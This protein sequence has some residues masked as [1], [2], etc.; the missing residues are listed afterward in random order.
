M[1][2]QNTLVE[3][4]VF[5]FRRVSLAVRS[6]PSASDAA[7]GTVRAA[8]RDSVS[9]RERVFRS[10]CFIGFLQKSAQLVYIT[11]I[12]IS[13]SSLK[14]NVKSDTKSDRVSADFLIP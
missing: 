12:T 11:Q 2:L 14:V 4:W 8:A 5:S 13:H 6:L 7:A 9:S 3:S 10:K 1:L